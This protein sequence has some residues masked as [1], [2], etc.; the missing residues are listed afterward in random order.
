MKGRIICSLLVAVLLVPVWVGLTLAGNLQPGAPPAPTMKT[1]DQIPPTWDQTLPAAT[2]FQSV[3]N[4]AA[5]LDK[6]T[7]L[8]WENSPTG[9]LYNGYLFAL[10]ACL[11]NA[12]G[13]RGGW[14]LPRAEELGSLLPLPSGHP[15][16]LTALTP[17]VRYGFWSSTPSPPVDCESASS[18][19][20]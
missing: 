18:W 3:M 8:V 15:F 11:R 12:T 14:R 13:G 1:L 5:F 9:G 10:S 4:G 2:R 19:R 16:S 17:S 6:E 7:G 20:H